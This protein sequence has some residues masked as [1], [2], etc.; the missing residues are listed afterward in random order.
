M[1]KS[2]LFLVFFLFCFTL[3]SQCPT[4]TII[5]PIGNEEFVNKT[6]V[7]IVFHYG[8]DGIMEFM[9]V[10][11]VYFY[12]YVDGGETGILESTIPIDGSNFANSQVI[13]YTWDISKLSSDNCLIKVQKYEWGCWAESESSFSIKRSP[14]IPGNDEGCGTKI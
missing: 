6:S 10:D 8:L 3:K 1:K 7:E 12:Y 11:F 9:P 5:Y 4:P 14:L 13:E 2:I